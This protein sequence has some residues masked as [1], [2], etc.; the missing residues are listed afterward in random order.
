MEHALA[1]RYLVFVS[2]AFQ[3]SHTLAALILKSLT[4]VRIISVFL[5]L[6]YDVETFIQIS[7]EGIH[8]NIQQATLNTSVGYSIRLWCHRQRLWM[9]EP[10]SRFRIKVEFSAFIYAQIHLRKLR[11]HLLSPSCR[12]NSE[13]AR[14][15]SCGC[16]GR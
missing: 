3:C 8:K 16:R 15:F 4:A 14:P 11:I 1:V 6:I 2:S 9:R 10:E 12:L 5:N 7:A 13:K